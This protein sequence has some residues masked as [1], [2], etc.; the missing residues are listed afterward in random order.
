M[1]KKGGAALGCL[2][3]IAAVVVALVASFAIFALLDLL[4]RKLLIGGEDW[5][6]YEP[7]PYAQKMIIFP[8][9]ILLMET[10]MAF[11]YMKSGVGAFESSY[12]F[13]NLM[14]NHKLL[15]VVV[16]VLVLY[17]GFTGIS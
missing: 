3:L 8:V 17:A 14:V 7:M 1:K 16:C 10:I 9:V 6:F 2:L 13:V 11:M 5:I 15:V 12:R 4:Q